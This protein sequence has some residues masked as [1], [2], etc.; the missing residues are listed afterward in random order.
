TVADCARMLS[1]MVGY[2]AKATSGHRYAIDRAAPLVSDEKAYQDMTGAK[3]DYTRYLDNARGLRGV[4]IGVVKALYGK[5]P[6]VNEAIDS[7]LEKMRS[8]G[9]IVSEVTVQDLP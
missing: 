2:D 1:V 5:D 9:A 6:I 7:A 8:A 3:K 4:R